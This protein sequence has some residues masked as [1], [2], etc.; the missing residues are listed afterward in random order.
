MDL[1]K[2]FELAE[3]VSAQKLQPSCKLNSDTM[4]RP[5]YCNPVVVSS[6]QALGSSANADAPTFSVN[7]GNSRPTPEMISAAQAQKNVSRGATDQVSRKRR[8]LP[9]SFQTREL[10]HLRY[11]GNIQYVST[12]NAAEHIASQLLSSSNI[13][14]LGSSYQPKALPPVPQRPALAVF[15]FDIEWRVTYKVF[16]YK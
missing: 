16:V 15:G 13:S 12:P 3:A 7:S 6:E 5:T 8:R 1:S 9:A 11:T 4:P 2:L 14:A 10:P